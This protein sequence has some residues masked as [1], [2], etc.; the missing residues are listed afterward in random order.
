MGDDH[1][2]GG[3]GTGETA[4]QV[5]R[6]DRAYGRARPVWAEV[7]LDAIGANLDEIRRR[8]GRPARI[9]ATVKADAYGHGIVPVGRYLE[10][11]GVDA[12]ATANLD[13]AVALREHGVRL[14]IL[15]FASNLPEGVGTL[16][17]YGLTP[18]V[19]DIATARGISE[20]ATGPVN[21]HV[22]VDAGLGRLGVKL[23]HARELILQVARLPHLTVEGVYTHIAFSDDVGEAWS[24]RRLAA[25]T[26]LISE[27]QSRDGL[28]IRYAEA[29]ASSVIACGFPDSLNTVAPGHLLF[30]LCPVGPG[31]A[32]M[33]GFT[34]ALQR[35]AARLIHVVD[36]E[37]G[38]DIAV[39]GHYG[40]SSGA[41]TGVILCGLD[42]GLRMPV[43]DG[44]DMLCHGRRCPI[45]SVTAEYTVIDL[46]G[47]EDP[48]IG[49]TV[50]LI[51]TD[52]PETITLE[53][54]ARYLGVGSPARLLVDLRRIP[55]RY[56]G[57]ADRDRGTGMRA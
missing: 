45:V 14:P 49:D 30:G 4:G 39:S 17:A 54:V 26:D 36:H 28:T 51:G 23:R 22:K 57:P 44:G 46:S 41:R 25:F 24:R 55:M 33:T 11:I 27:L 16:L 32:D 43:A 12:L 1:R 40:L 47:V 21:V 5:H 2:T 9:I 34:P 15:M 3:G 6:S 53:Q 35:V 31:Q 56:P 10:R 7:H 20:I 8:V 37:A 52:G 18:T 50:T 38:D 13:D 48:R 19:Y 42:N 29:S